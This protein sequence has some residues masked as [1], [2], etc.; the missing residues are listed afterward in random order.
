MNACHSCNNNR[1]DRRLRGNYDVFAAVSSFMP[2]SK[3]VMLC[4]V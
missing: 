2:S 3:Y 4:A 1:D